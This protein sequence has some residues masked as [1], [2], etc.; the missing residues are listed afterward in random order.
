MPP[1]RKKRIWS[2]VKSGLAYAWSH[3]NIRLSAEL[4]LIVCTLNFN[5]NVI[6]PI[7]AKTVLHSGAQTY[8]NLLSAT[9]IGSLIAAFLMSYLSR[10]GLQRNIYLFTGIGAASVQALMPFVHSFSG[11]NGNDGGQ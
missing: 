3:A 4:I 1:H 11:G 7:F 5:N 2:D 8:A 10:F 6:I 9:G